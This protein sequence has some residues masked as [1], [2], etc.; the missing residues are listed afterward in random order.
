MHQEKKS[1]NSFIPHSVSHRPYFSTPNNKLFPFHCIHTSAKFRHTFYIMPM[2][3]YIFCRKTT[4]RKYFPLRT[5][6]LI[7]IVTESSHKS[8]CCIEG[9]DHLQE[10][11]SSEG[12]T[13]FMKVLHVSGGSFRVKTLIK[14][15]FCLTGEKF[16]F[17]GFNLVVLIHHNCNP[18]P[19]QRTPKLGL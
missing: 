16:I 3:I 6:A 4:K 19:N 13:A 17:S 14:K 7:L 15:W 8:W 9:L 10:K 2:Y 18:I 11:D 12:R 1:I 5:F